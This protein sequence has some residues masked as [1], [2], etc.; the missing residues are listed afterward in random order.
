MCPPK[1]HLFHVVAVS[2]FPNLKEN[3]LQ[4]FSYYHKKKE[5]IISNS[6]QHMTETSR[7]FEQEKNIPV[8]LI[9]K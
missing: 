1:E 8:K 7:V 6:L 3:L 9:A 2:S 4:F 5:I